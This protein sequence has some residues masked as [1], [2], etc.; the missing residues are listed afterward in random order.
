MT[1]SNSL[2]ILGVCYEIV[3]DKEVAYYCYDFTLQHEYDIC[4]SVAKRK[5]NLNMT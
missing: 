1:L 5:V 3:G 2:S 4:R